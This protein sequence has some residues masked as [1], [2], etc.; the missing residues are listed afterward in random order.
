MNTVYK[1]ESCLCEKLFSLGS[2]KILI[3]WDFRI[4]IE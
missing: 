2:I 3:V 4:S 1:S